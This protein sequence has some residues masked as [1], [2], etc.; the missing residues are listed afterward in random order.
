MECMHVCMYVMLCMYVC[1]HVYVCILA[2]PLCSRVFPAKKHCFPA[3][4]QRG[5]PKT[6]GFFRFS[7]KGCR[8]PKTAKK[9][10]RG[11]EP[12]TP[13]LPTPAHRRLRLVKL[14]QI[15]ARYVGPPKK[16]TT[17]LTSGE[18]GVILYPLVS[19]RH[20]EQCRRIFRTSS[21]LAPQKLDI[22]F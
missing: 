11:I 9:P 2:P 3:Y 16:K 20:A 13:V 7:A 4:S 12:G 19:I 6:L 17:Y 10:A 18:G 21:I 1:M 5:R 22:L 8:K 14:R 15:A